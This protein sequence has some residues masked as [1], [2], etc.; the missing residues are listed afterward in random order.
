M[1]KP[2]ANYFIVGEKMAKYLQELFYE[3][4]YY[5]EI[6]NI[7]LYKHNKYGKK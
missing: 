5:N 7:K 2:T 6:E 1:R 4:D 3:D